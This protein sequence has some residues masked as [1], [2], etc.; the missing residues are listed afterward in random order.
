MLQLGNEPN[1]KTWCTILEQTGPNQKL[2]LIPDRDHG[3]R[4][5]RTTPRHEVD[6]FDLYPDGDNSDDDD[7]DDDD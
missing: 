1:I 7:S 6:T 5:E 4:K 2:R 3:E